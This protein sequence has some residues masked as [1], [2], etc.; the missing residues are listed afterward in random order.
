[1][2]LANSILGYFNLFDN[3]ILLE[4]GIELGLKFFS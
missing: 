3:F 2:S 1:M 4:I